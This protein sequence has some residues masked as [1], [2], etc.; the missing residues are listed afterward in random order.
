M[1]I[2]PVFSCRVT[3]SVEVLYI[4]MLTL[5]LDGSKLCDGDVGA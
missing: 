2:I 1:Y 4:H 5:D 3:C